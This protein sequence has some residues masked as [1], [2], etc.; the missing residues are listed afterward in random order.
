MHSISSC[1]NLMMFRYHATTA[2][3]EAA[4]FPPR[5]FGVERFDAMLVRSGGAANILTLDVST[6]RPPDT[7]IPERVAKQIGR[8]RATRFEIGNE[9]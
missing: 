4:G 9:V 1:A 7:S 5:V 8:D 3:V 2:A 6:V